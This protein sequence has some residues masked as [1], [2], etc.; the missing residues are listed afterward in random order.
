MYDVVY[1]GIKETPQLA[2]H[3][4]ICLHELQHAL[5][6]REEFQKESLKTRNMFHG[7]KAEM[8]EFLGQTTVTAQHTE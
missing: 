2:P 7:E 8:G 3:N 1:K 5:S 6:G 4:E